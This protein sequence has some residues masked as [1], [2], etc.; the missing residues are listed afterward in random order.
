MTM[1]QQHPD[2]HPAPFAE[3]LPGLRDPR[4]GR[5]RQ[6][7]AARA[8]AKSSLRA[9][10]AERLA[11]IRDGMTV[12]VEDPGAA[13]LPE[14]PAAPPRRAITGAHPRAEAAAAAPVPDEVIETPPRPEIAQASPPEIAA[15]SHSAE[16]AGPTRPGETI[17]SPLRGAAPIPREI[18]EASAR[19][20]AGPDAGPEGAAD[21]DPE[22]DPE[23]DIEALERFL[24]GLVGALEAEPVPQPARLDSAVVALDRAGGET[25]QGAGAAGGAE[26]GGLARLP[27]AGPG[28]IAALGRAGVADLVTLA[29][30]D[31]E[32]LAVRLGPIGR[33]I[34]LETWIAIARAETAD[35]AAAAG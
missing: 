28:L 17:A 26:A 1:N 3:A 24:A 32:S 25:G 33:L 31:P 6:A 21:D 4:P 11:R 13:D 18:A 30:L 23:R 2:C 34:D 22:R 35:P 5:L 14:P 10:R 8:E 29:R 12:L 20:E 19:E 27:G 9:R 7:L 15:P 16:I